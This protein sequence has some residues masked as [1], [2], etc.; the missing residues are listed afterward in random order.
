MGDPNGLPRG[1]F[2]SGLNQ[3]K[4]FQHKTRE[5]VARIDGQLEE[6]GSGL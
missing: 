5:Q 4:A 1:H 2:N 6:L 3:L